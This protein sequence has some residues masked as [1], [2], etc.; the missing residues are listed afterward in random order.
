MSEKSYRY[1]NDVLV[2]NTA[3]D[4][5]R[6]NAQ[7]VLIAAADL[8]DLKIFNREQRNQLL[9][10]SDW[11]QMPDSPLADEAK[12]SWAT[13]RTSLRTLPTHENW[14]SLEDADWPTK[15]S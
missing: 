14:P 7:V 9:A 5:E 11:T 2:E 15:P 12:T 8:E 3:E 6:I 4:I 10:D 13:Y 1:E